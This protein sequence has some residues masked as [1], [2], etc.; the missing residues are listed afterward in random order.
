M[1]NPIHEAGETARSA[2]DVF[3]TSPFTL[4]LILMNLALLGFL[5]LFSIHAETERTRALE[6]LY[7]NRKYV[8]DILSR[9]YPVP[10]SQ[11]H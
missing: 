7:E 8:G 3:R 11:H 6:L 10:P 1:Q 9:C 5:Y 2:I 4:A